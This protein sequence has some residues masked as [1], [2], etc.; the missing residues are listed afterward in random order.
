[1][2]RSLFT[3]LSV[4]FCPVVLYAAGDGVFNGRYEPEHRA[5]MLRTLQKAYPELAKEEFDADGDGIVTVEEQETG[6]HP[7]QQLVLLSHKKHP[8]VLPGLHIPWTPDLFCEWISLSFFAEDA[9]EGAV[10]NLVPQGLLDRQPAQ[11]NAAV[12]PVRTPDGRISFP[13]GTGAHLRMDGDRNARWNYRWG[14]ITFRLDESTGER[15]VLLDINAG[16]GPSKSSPKV[17]YEKGKGLCA[18]YVGRGANGLDVR[19]LVSDAVIADGTN[20]NCIVFGMRQ[21]NMFG[22]VN[23]VP[24]K[25]TAAQPGRFSSEEAYRVESRIGDA[26]PESMAWSFDALLLGQTELSE[27]AVR[28]FDGWAARRLGFCA[29]LPEAHPY[30]TRAPRLD[31]EDL[32]HRYIHD[33]ETWLR[34]GESTK[35]KSLT[36]VNAGGARVEPEG[37]EL[38][39]RDD[40]TKFRIAPGTSSAGDLWMAPGFNSAVGGSARLL[41][42][43]RMPDVYGHDAEAG[44]QNVAL[45]EHAGKWYAGAF[46]SVNDM[47][48]GYTW[49]GEKI[50]R[51]RCMFPKRKKEDVAGGLFPAFWSYGTEWLYWRASNRIE[52]DWFEFDGIN[53]T[54]YN[55][56]STHYHYPHIKSVFA[57]NNDSYQ[58]F[59]VYGGLL[60]EEKGKIPGGFYLW[61]G[62]Y[63]TWEF[64]IGR[65]MT[66]VN[67]T[68]DDGNGGERWVEVC[69]TKTAPTYLERLDLQLDYALKAKQGNAVIPEDFFVD[70]IEVWQKSEAVNAVR[71]PFVSLPE[72]SG[73]AEPGGT[74]RCHVD[75][76]GI[77]DFRYYWFADGY[78]VTY[79]AGPELKITAE[80]SGKNLRCM[81]LAA[82]ALDMPEAWSRPVTVR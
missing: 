44:V 51:I 12:R 75:A 66:Y 47:G 6:R 2:K 60:N 82:G 74:V 3:C 59:K 16:R 61:D 58:R 72:L 18:Q 63:H 45:R 55:G 73:N 14:A 35:D 65:D 8:E 62:R 1:M 11:E 29:R 70:W 30:R 76:P 42:P 56:L 39:F 64:V 77:T 40:F 67:L 43:G 10:G 9:P 27:A 23:G 17:W 81:V 57:K 7:L 28:K 54:W 22:S 68:I 69:R 25:E 49:A 32:P 38:V 31:A 41:A 5:K 15:V 13:A 26:D 34:W 78:P 79:G 71:A 80:L 4:L 20:W 37:F 33:N 36:R 52:C 46:Y 50:F 21:G 19:K 53:G 48:Q 24:M